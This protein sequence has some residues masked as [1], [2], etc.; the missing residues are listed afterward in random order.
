M[1]GY[2]AAV[3]RILCVDGAEL[4]A[5]GRGAAEN[6]QDWEEEGLAKGVYVAWRASPGRVA[7]GALSRD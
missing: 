6:G 7:M 1:R 4:R 3:W 2:R 5:R